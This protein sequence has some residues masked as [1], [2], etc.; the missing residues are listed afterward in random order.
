MKISPSIE[1]N[2]NSSD[3]TPQGYVLNSDGKTCR[4][5]DECAT[6]VHTCQYECINT[7]GKVS[8]LF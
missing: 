7:L 3:F 1:P 8:V 2:K 6:G 4:D 5:L